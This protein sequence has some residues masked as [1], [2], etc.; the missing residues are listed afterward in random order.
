MSTPSDHKLLAETL[1]GV[2][3]KAA[4]QLFD[5]DNHLDRAHLFTLL[6]DR[7]IVRTAKQGGDENINTAEAIFKALLKNPP[8]KQRFFVEVG[9]ATVFKAKDFR[10]FFRRKQ[11]RQFLHRL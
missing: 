8:C 11:G 1:L 7:E 5:E 3:R 6:D 9:G 2:L 4:P 10:F